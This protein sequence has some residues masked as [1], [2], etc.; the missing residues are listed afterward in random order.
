MKADRTLVTH[1]TEQTEAEFLRLLEFEQ[2]RG[3]ANLTV[4]TLLKRLI[5]GYISRHK[6]DYQ[7]L[8]TVFERNHENS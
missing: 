3:D 6:S 2:N 1:V 8:K 7:S 4:S 5:E